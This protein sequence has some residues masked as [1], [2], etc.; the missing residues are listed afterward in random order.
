MKKIDLRILAELMRNS[1]MSDRQL[2]K[3]VGVSQPTITRRRA[4][5]EKGVISGYTTIPQWTSLGYEVLAITLIKTRQAAGTKEKYESSR[6]RGKK[7]L[8]IQP[9]IIM[10]GGC[11][12]LGADSFMISV[13]RSYPEYDEFLRNHRLEMGDLVEDVQSVLVNLSG[14]EILKP[15]HMRYLADSF[16]VTLR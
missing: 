2:A 8:M 12:G 16:E 14:E 4:R 10:S 13:H 1:K 11:R 9:Q 15:L 7:W 6:R 5:L 3:R